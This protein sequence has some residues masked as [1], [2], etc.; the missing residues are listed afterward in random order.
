[1]IVSVISECHELRQT[2]GP[3]VWDVFHIKLIWDSV[4][5]PIWYSPAIWLAVLCLV[6]FQ[7]PAVQVC[8]T[9]YT[10]SSVCSCIG[11]TQSIVLCVWR[12]WCVWL[13]MAQFINWVTM[14]SFAMQ[15]I[16]SLISF[17]FFYSLE[18]CEYVI[19]SIR[20]AWWLLCLAKT[21]MLWFSQTSQMW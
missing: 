5:W 10:P 13:W 4:T 17:F 2:S 15:S 1:M 8:F 12:R 19:I 14:L 3:C 21:W 11:T 6:A 9:N 7:S 16:S 18:K 20:Q